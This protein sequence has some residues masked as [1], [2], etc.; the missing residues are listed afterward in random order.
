M[1][2]KDRNAK[3][4]DFKIT[5]ED[6]RTFLTCSAIDQGKPFMSI[7]LLLGDEDQAIFVKE[8]FLEKA[9]EIYSTV[10]DILT[11]SDKEN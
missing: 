5:K 6:N 3:E 11:K 8:K 10:F 4:T 1:L 7:K 2:V 9:S